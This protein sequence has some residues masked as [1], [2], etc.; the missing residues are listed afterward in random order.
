[1][2]EQPPVN[3]YQYLYEQPSVTSAPDFV[4]YVD[5]ITGE[6]RRFRTCLDRISAAAT[7]LA[8]PVAHGGLGL[9]ADTS[10][11]VGILSENCLVRWAS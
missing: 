2:P 4:A 6:Q 5:G 8:A 3:Y 1:M 7:A 11:M 10:D 9:R